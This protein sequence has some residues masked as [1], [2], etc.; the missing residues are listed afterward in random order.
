M[1]RSELT[2]ILRRGRTE[3]WATDEAYQ[4]D[5]VASGHAYP[6][7]D[8]DAGTVHPAVVSAYQMEKAEG[9][10]KKIHT[11]TLAC[12][13]DDD[14]WVWC[15]DTFLEGRHRKKG[16]TP[17]DRR[18]QA[19]AAIHS[20]RRDD[21]ERHMQALFGSVAA[22][23]PC[24]FWARWKSDQRPCK[25]V[26]TALN[27]LAAS[28]ELD[29]QLDLLA[30]EYK[31]FMHGGIAADLSLG[32]DEAALIE[33]LAF[34]RPVLLE[35]DRG[36]GKTITSRAFA[37]RCGFP[38][39]SVDGHEGMEAV[40]LLGHFV[41]DGKGG[42]VWKDGYLSEAF[43]LAA[44]TK[45][46]LLIDEMLRIDVKHLSPFLSALSP[47][48]GK[49]ALN[50]GRIVDVVDGVGRVE[51]LECPVENLCVIATTNIGGEYAVSALD[52]ALAERF[53]PIRK[54]TKPE[55]VE[56]LT[57]ESLTAKGFDASL[58][59]KLRSF[60][61]KMT[62]MVQQ[63]MAQHAPTLRTL[64]GALDMAESQ[65][66]IR[67]WLKQ[68]ALLWVGRDISGYPVPDQLDAVYRLIDKE[69]A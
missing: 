52:P 51:R 50:T 35:G 19:L 34:R 65:S 68:S 23:S 33:R 48:D 22:N 61:I 46:V 41:V 59:A 6:F 53:V 25:H 55:D 69:F 16:I 11:V 15:G 60:F 47:F 45:T 36:S 30:A 37:K 14:Y 57:A 26:W 43:R 66:E 27:Q 20:S 21:A 12:R 3:S 40:D 7:L 32:L 38:L 39:V 5:L 2:G 29:K 17:S 54:D 64:S 62:Q 8:L 63:G 18:I 58:A 67:V 31:A 9:S 49:Y 1:Q 10:T 56:R 28:G 13:G 42:W 4:I 24:N 44:R